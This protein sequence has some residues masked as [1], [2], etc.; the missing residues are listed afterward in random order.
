MSETSYGHGISPSMVDVD[1]SGSGKLTET[2]AQYL[3]ARFPR[4][5]DCCGKTFK[6]PQ[7]FQMHIYWK[8]NSEFYKV[9]VQSFLAGTIRLE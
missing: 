3:K 9:F 6:T 1:R 8:H 2:L 5:P 4:Y 7:G